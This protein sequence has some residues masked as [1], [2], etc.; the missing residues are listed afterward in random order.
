MT[1][2]IVS[3]GI[4]QVVGFKHGRKVVDLNDVAELLW[5]QPDVCI[6]GEINAGV[7]YG[8]VPVFELGFD[9]IIKK[10]ERLCENR[11]NKV[12]GNYVIRSHSLT[13]R[14]NIF[15]IKSSISFVL[16]FH[17]NLQKYLGTKTTHT[18]KSHTLGSLINVLKLNFIHGYLISIL[19]YFTEYKSCYIII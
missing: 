16:I 17:L 3:K 5:V 11:Q 2:P 9:L 18:Q 4:K 8:D 7:E 10:N 14:T 1:S 6:G 15:T 12:D 13:V 19:P